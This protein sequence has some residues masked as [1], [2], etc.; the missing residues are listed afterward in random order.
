MPRTPSPAST[1][2][3]PLALLPGKVPDPPFVTTSLPPLL[4]STL[5][6]VEPLCMQCYR[7]EANML[8]HF[9][10][11]LRVRVSQLN[12]EFT[13]GVS[14]ASHLT[15][16]EHLFLPSKGLEL[17]MSCHT[18][19]AL[20]GCWGSQ[21]WPSHLHGTVPVEPFPQ[22]S[23]A[24]LREAMHPSVLSSNECRNSRLYSSSQ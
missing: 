18:N 5:C 19:P 11:L 10:P 21:L 2:G 16:R 6:G 9:P 12:P 17:E 4:P 8:H 22:L 15:L 23:R 1:F 3:W 13:D 20:H 7:P 14:P 24:F